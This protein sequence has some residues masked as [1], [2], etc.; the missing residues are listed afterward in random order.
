MKK[1]IAKRQDTYFQLPDGSSQLVSALEYPQLRA[2]FDAATGADEFFLTFIGW[3][4]RTVKNPSTFGGRTFEEFKS[5]LDE[6]INNLPAVT[7]KR[8]TIVLVGADLDDRWHQSSDT[9]T[10]R[11][12]ADLP[13]ILQSAGVDA[14]AVKLHIRNGWTVIDKGIVQEKYVTS[15]GQTL[16]GDLATAFDLLH[17]AEY[18]F[19]SKTRA[20]VRRPLSFTALHDAGA[21]LEKICDDK[22]TAENNALLIKEL[23]DLHGAA[24]R[25]RIGRPPLTVEHR[26][27]HEAMLEKIKEAHL[28]NREKE[29][30]IAAGLEVAHRHDPDVIY[31]PGLI[32]QNE[33]GEDE[34]AVG[35]PVAHN[36]DEIDPASIFWVST[37]SGA[38]SA[39]YRRAAECAADFQAGVKPGTQESGHLGLPVFSGRSEADAVATV[40]AGVVLQTL[41]AKAHA[42]ESGGSVRTG[43]GEVIE[44]AKPSSA[45]RSEAVRNIMDVVA[46]LHSTINALNDTYVGAAVV[47]VKVNVA[48]AQIIRGL[49]IT[50]TNWSEALPK[51]NRAFAGLGIA[52]NVASVVSAAKAL[53]DAKTGAEKAIAGENLG[54]AIT[55]LGIG[56]TGTIAGI[57]G[58]GSIAAACSYLGVPLIGLDFGIKQVVKGYARRAENIDQG[59]AM[60]NGIGDGVAER[61]L[62]LNKHGFIQA[63][64]EAVITEIDLSKNTFKF[65][66]VLILGSEQPII[67]G[68]PKVT[69]QWISVYEAYGVNNKTFSALNSADAAAQVIV[70]PSALEKRIKYDYVDS[71]GHGYHA[72]VARQLEKYFDGTHGK[73]TFYFWKMAYPL[74]PIQY[75][76]D[77]VEVISQ[78]TNIK[79]K[80]DERSRAVI[81]PPIPDKVYREKLSYLIEGGSGQYSLT[82]NSWHIDTTIA[83][84]ANKDETWLIDLTAAGSEMIDQSVIGQWKR[85]VIKNLQVTSKALTVSNHTIKFKD[86]KPANLTLKFDVKD[87]SEL[88]LLLKWDWKKTLTMCCYLHRKMTYCLAKISRNYLNPRKSR[89]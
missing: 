12:G 67:L 44:S 66:D 33:A 53:S 38:I 71:P 86:Q 13:S 84:S 39:W 58:I 35:R 59:M 43:S 24:F 40:A 8:L 34:I 77:E 42:A 49:D 1:D 16:T 22:A 88:S 87:A 82:T 46:K 64:A 41:L 65:G 60:L 73:P 51:P 45:E 83:P 2:T 74:I 69:D 63:H 21:L 5:S 20:Y 26:D 17:S 61:R 25:E 31:V 4:G 3:N 52:M 48:L 32:R 75:I 11:L 76:M 23:T 62:T 30:A 78:N 89:V 37:T 36:S 54:M 55:S 57:V 72:P 56:T 9:F 79:L 81:V 15:K 29:A 70:L 27:A 6:D 18:V 80:L 14:E 68:A 10:G 50:K 28:L 19:D 7:V 85:D 47:G